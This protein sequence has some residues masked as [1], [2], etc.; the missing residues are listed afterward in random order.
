MSDETT[1][2]FPVLRLAEESDAIKVLARGD[3]GIADMFAYQAGAA[4][5]QNVLGGGHSR[6]LVVQVEWRWLGK[7]CYGDTVLFSVDR[8]RFYLPITCQGARRQ[9]WLC[10]RRREYMRWKVAPRQSANQRCQPRT[11]PRSTAP[12]DGGIAH[13]S[14]TTFFCPDRLELIRELLVLQHTCILLPSDRSI[15]CTCP[16]PL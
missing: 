11:P 13:P 16:S 12:H 6:C 5:D 2:G 7:C 15:R 4:D 14:T 3:D 8:V 10:R 9:K 1:S